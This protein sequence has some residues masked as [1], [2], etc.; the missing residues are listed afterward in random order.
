[1]YELERRLRGQA[2]TSRT[3]LVAVSGWGQA[4]DQRRAIEAGFDAFLVKP[5]DP[6][7]IVTL[8]QRP[9]VGYLDASVSATRPR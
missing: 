6:E 5:V 9:Y 4:H 8:I 2:A 7:R 3:I 1:M